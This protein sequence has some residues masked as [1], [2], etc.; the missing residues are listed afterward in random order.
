M[1]KIFLEDS[2]GDWVAI[3]EMRLAILSFDFP[4]TIGGVQTYLF[5]IAKR[6]GN[7]CEV[8]VITSTTGLLKPDPPFERFNTASRKAVDFW[9]VLHVYQP[10][11]VLVG[12]A[13]PQLL[14]A[15]NLY[16]FHKYSAIA[17]GNDYLAAQRL[18]HR[19]IFN[20]LLRKARPLIA[21]SKVHATRLQQIGMTAPVIIY[22]ETDP[23]RFSPIPAPLKMPSSVLTIS[24]LVPRKG[25][26]TVIYAGLNYFSEI[27]QTSSTSLEV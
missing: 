2:D 14:L 26:D 16:S 7:K 13:H 15:A 21:I 8:C 17:Y 11:R 25:I 24:R 4:P 18:W 19:P 20:H 23:D 10:E 9:R 3:S 5:E 27:F 12:H 22:P 1:P 6:L